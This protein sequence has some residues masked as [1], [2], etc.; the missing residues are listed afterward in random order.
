MP[1]E[2]A[3]C[4]CAGTGAYTAEVPLSGAVVL[5][6]RLCVAHVARR[7]LV[8]ERE[9]PARIGEVMDIV[10]TSQ[11]IRVYLRARGGGREWD[12]DLD[13]LEPA[14]KERGGA[15][16]INSISAKPR[17]DQPEER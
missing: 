2:P 16:H 1:A 3:P 6:Q 17:G 12:V 15:P 13:A 5:V 7:T 11:G 4:R 10:K 8:R 14:P 9:R